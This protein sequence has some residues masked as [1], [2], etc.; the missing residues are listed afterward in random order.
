MEIIEN[1]DS[2]PVKIDTIEKAL[3]IS[4]KRM[5]MIESIVRYELRP[6]CKKVGDLLH[7]VALC[8]DLTET[9]KV[10]TAYKVSEYNSRKGW[11]KKWALEDRIRWLQNKV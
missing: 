9:E 10:Y 5:K 3:G 2:I 11:L 7:A 4:D 1:S 8:E 6:A